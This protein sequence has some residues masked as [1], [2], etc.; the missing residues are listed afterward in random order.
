[1][2]QHKGAWAKVPMQPIIA[3]APLELLHV[4]FI[5]I[6]MTMGLDQTPNMV[7]VFIFC[8]VFMKHIMANV[9]PDQTTK[10]V[11]KFLWQGCILIFKALA[12]FLSDWGANFESNIVK[13]LCELMGI[14]KVRTSPHHTQTNDQVERAHQTL[15][16]MTGIISRDQKAHWPKHLPELVHAYNSMRSAITGYSL[17]YIML[18][19]QP[20]LP[21]HLYFPT[22]RGME[23][24]QHVGH[25]VAKL[26]EQLWEA[27]KEV[28]EQSTSKAERQKLYYHRKANAYSLEKGDMV[29]VEAHP[30]RGRGKCRTSGRRNCM[31][32]NTKLL[33]DR[34]LTSS[35]T[36]SHQSDRDD[37]HLYGCASYMGPVHPTTLEE[38]TLERSETKEAPQSVNCLLSAQQQTVETS[39]GWVNRKL[40]VIL[41]MF[42][43]V[44]LFLQR[45]TVHCRGTVS[46]RESM[47]VLQQL[48]CWSHWWGQKDTTGHNKLNFTSLHSGDCKLITLGKG[49]GST[50][51]CIHFW[52]TNSSSTLMLQ[53]FLVSPMQ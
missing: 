15:M 25:Y 27:F 4:D 50:G 16:H 5:S 6:E 13:E 29:L 18:G 11:A 49:N 53:E 12:K 32:W 52:M 2:F 46:V 22:I 23:K 9:T 8:D 28:Q 35:L 39:L 17:H 36:L 19:C 20:Y 48:I 40:C 7:S 47:L 21:I 10:T 37:S 42:S 31:K 24:H 44:S 43:R 30:Y 1:M 34:T 38:E 51:L 45:W 3:T 26:H 41:R 33:K 14:K